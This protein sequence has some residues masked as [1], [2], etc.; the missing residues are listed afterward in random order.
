M[1]H[2]RMGILGLLLAGTAVADDSALPFGNIDGCMQGPMAQFGRYIGDWSI[3]EKTL[4][5]DGTE[6]TT[7]P[8]ARWIFT[9]LGNG[10]AVQDFWLPANGAVG[11]TIRSYD[12]TSQAWSVVWTTT[13]MPGFSF[14]A[15]ALNDEDQVIMTY[16]SPVADPERRVTFFP[17]DDTGWS[18]KLEIRSQDDEWIEV[19]RIR[20][21]RFEG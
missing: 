19:Y 17:P 11:T 4:S 20:A 15:A 7:G 14:R 18:W 12:P 13:G 2:V 1:N 10:T 16:V 3:E 8:G 6:W 21:T 9:C 5:Q